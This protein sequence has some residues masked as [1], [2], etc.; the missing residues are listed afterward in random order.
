M[1]PTSRLLVGTSFAHLLGGGILGVW[2]LAA[3][4]GPAPVSALPAVHAELMLL[5]W[6]FQLAAGVALWILPRSL[7]GGPA[8]SPAVGRVVWLLLQGGLGFAALGLAGG[9]A[10]AL[11]LGRILELA[12]VATFG[13]HAAHRIRLVP[14]PTP[15]RPR[16][17]PSGAGPDR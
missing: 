14:G 11:V 12:A 15:G 16:A 9:P 4:R 5:G 3:S 10:I 13:W 7:H 8:R 2:W 6:V 17:R 1:P